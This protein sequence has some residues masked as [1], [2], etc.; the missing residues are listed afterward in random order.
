MSAKLD[1]T[2]DRPETF[3]NWRRVNSDMTTSYA[4][5]SANPFQLDFRLRCPTAQDA[6]MPQKNTNAARKYNK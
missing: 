2:S 5:I 4:V 1:P 6:P 3:K